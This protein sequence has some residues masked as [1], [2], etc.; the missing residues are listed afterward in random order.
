[1]VVS[2]TVSVRVSNHF[3]F[4]TCGCSQDFLPRRGKSAVGKFIKSELEYKAAK[5]KKEN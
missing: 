2:L 4:D 3:I 1:M 5:K